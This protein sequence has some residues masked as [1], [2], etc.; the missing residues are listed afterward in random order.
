[1]T[2]AEAPVGAHVV[3]Q[4][5]ERDRYA[6]EAIRL[7]VTAGRELTV[8]QNLR[9]GPVVVDTGVSEVAIGYALA[10]VIRVHLLSV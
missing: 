8:L 1:M 7:G 4:A 6:A 3:V 5:F 2:L 10:R 9:R